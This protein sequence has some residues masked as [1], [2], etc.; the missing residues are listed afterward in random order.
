LSWLRKPTVHP[1]R[2]LALGVGGG[3]VALAALLLSLQRHSGPS[4]SPRVVMLESPPPAA[5]VE[6]TA[7]AAPDPVASPVPSP[8]TVPKPARETRPKAPRGSAAVQPDAAALSRKFKA[9]QP[10]IESCFRRQTE[11]VV[12][13]P[14]VSVRFEV[15]RAGKV[16]RASL[17]PATLSETPLGRCLLQTAETARF[18]ELTEPVAFSIPIT[19][20]RGAEPN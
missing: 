12:G 16:T 3:L 9:K 13:T 17:S 8:P 10:Q 19:A 5:P 4:A 11:Q 18:G 6:A 7:S 15:D 20:H 1:P 14:R 2:A